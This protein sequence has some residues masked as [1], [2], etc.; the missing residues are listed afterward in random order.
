MRITSKLLRIRRL[1]AL[2]YG[3][4]KSRIDRSRVSTKAR[5]WYF[6]RN[7]TKASNE[8]YFLDKDGKFET[9]SDK[10]VILHLYHPDTWEP[11]FLPKLKS[12]AQACTFDLFITMPAENVQ[13]ISTVRAEFPSANFLIVPNKGRDVL[14]FIKTAKLIADMSYQKIL[15]IHSKKSVHRQTSNTA[16]AGSGDEWLTD[17][18]NALIPNESS[19][20]HELLNELDDSTTGIIGPSKYFYPLKM[21]LRYNRPFIEELLQ[22]FVDDAFFSVA[23]ADQLKKLG[24]FGG[25]MFWIDVKSITPVLNISSKNFQPETGQLDR[26]MAHALERVLCVLPQLGG[27]KVYGS[28][29]NHIE[30]IKGADAVFPSWYYGDVSGGKPQ[31]SII[32]PVYADWS[33][34]QKNIKSLRREVGNSE[35]ISVH[36]VNDCGPDADDLEEKILASTRGLTNFYYHRNDQNLGFVQT[37]NHSVFDLVPQGDDV[38]LLNSDTKVTRNFLVEMRKTLY[39]GNDIA[40]VTSRSN[41][42]TI[43][44]VPMTSRLA[45]HR[46]ASYLLYRLI[47]SRLPDRYITPTI[48]GFCVLIR[49]EVIKKYGLF[50]EIYGKG[51]GEEN[52]FAMRLRLHGWKCAVANKSYVFHYESRS[53][54]NDVRNKQIETNE[55]I[56]LERY[57]NYRQLVQEY[58]D[59]IKEP[60]K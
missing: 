57:P 10:A 53:F 27:R 42:A 45:H 58:W 37:C 54:G 36:Y 5:H 30:L 14:P 26:T 16:D 24:Y 1:P 2:G 21:Y 47:R 43:W 4:L 20:M 3:A 32:V 15:K 11:V 51:Y 35:D 33:S 12:L 56:L 23:R 25:T 31:I 34:L 44:S 22:P 29:G 60:L 48:H 8:N 49:R 17:T 41:N 18:L 50:D 40:A 6:T 52:D 38:L 13:S 39:S 55:K 19:V 9:T 46:P 28:T 7:N 59:G